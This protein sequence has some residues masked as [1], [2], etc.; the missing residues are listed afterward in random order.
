[1][2]RCGNESLVPL[3]NDI[4]SRLRGIRDTVTWDATQV[5]FMSRVLA[6]Y[7]GCGVNNFKPQL[8]AGNFMPQM[9]GAPS[10][11]SLT[12]E[13]EG[14]KKSSSEPK[15]VA[16]LKKLN[17][18]INDSNKDE[19]KL[20]G[21]RKDSIAK[22]KML[23]EAATER[24]QRYAVNAVVQ[25]VQAKYDK[26]HAEL[27]KTRKE[28]NDMRASNTDINSQRTQVALLKEQIKTKEKEIKAFEGRM[29][30]ATKDSQ[31]GR[32]ASDRVLKLVVDEKTALEYELAAAKKLIE[33]QKVQLEELEAVSSDLHDA[34][35]A[36]DEVQADMKTQLAKAQNEVDRLRAVNDK[37]NKDRNDHIQ[38]RNASESAK[39]EERMSRDNSQKKIENDNKLLTAGFNK[40]IEDLL[41]KHGDE[42]RKL[43]EEHL[44]AIDVLK[45]AH[46]IESIRTNESNRT[47][48]ADEATHA[49]EIDKLKAAHEKEINELEAAHGREIADLKEAHDEEMTAA[50]QQL[51]D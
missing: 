41:S 29:A 33:I 6:S 42:I 9:F 47:I 34:D 11:E 21:E 13:I 3:Y 7:Q 24:S 31:I 50:I 10:W 45:E 38:E 48:E 4:T 14:F 16:F 39:S 37:L 5:A 36:L 35:Q 40:S 20:L 1:M 30:N 25:A 19:Q 23:E 15:F 32:E 8:C 18:F 27:V 2:G 17:K 51:E 43:K 12:T 22:V 26:E 28:L 46:R 49:K 44:A